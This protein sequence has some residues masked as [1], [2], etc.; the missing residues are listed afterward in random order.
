M[1]NNSFTRINHFYI[2]VS[3]LYIIINKLF[4]QKIVFLLIVSKVDMKLNKNPKVGYFCKKPVRYMAFSHLASWSC[5]P[6]GIYIYIYN[7]HFDKW[8]SYPYGQRE[9]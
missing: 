5:I 7:G 6:L 2:V 1:V 3:N 4:I 8:G 9:S